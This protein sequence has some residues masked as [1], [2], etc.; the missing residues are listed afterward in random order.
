M[1]CIPNRVNEPTCSAIYP[2]IRTPFSS[3]ASQFLIPMVPLNSQLSVGRVPHNASS[4]VERF[5]SAWVASN[6]EGSYKRSVTLGIAI[7]FGNLNG[8]VTANIV[9]QLC[10]RRDKPLTKNCSIGPLTNPGTASVTGLCWHTL[11]SASFLRRFS[12]GI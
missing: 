5:N 12:P 9:S 10:R 3:V 6:V 7:G 4:C 11:R 1:P 2:T 8:A